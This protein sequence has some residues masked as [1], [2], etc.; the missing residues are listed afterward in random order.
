MNRYATIEKL[1]NTNEF[2]G[3]QGT[4]YYNITQYPEVPTNENDIWVE[5]DFGDRL[6]LLANQFYNDV[7]LY[8]IITIANPNKINAGS[9][10]LTPGTQIRI[11]V[12]VQEIVD[13]YI[14][15]NQ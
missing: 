13:S 15:L 7:T 3:T 10:F 1:R 4:Q 11:P 6:D 5:T 9:L 8:W 12:N 14:I 2:V